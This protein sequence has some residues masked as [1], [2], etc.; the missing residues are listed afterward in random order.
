MPHIPSFRFDMLL[1]VRLQNLGINIAFGVAFI[2]ALLIFTEYSTTAS[3]DTP[4]TLF[5]RG[6]KSKP[7]KTAAAPD[8]EGGASD[9]KFAEEKVSAPKSAS[10]K[11]TVPRMTD[12]FSWRN[13]NYVVPIPGKEDRKLLDDVSGYV[14]PGKLT[15]LMGESGAGKTTLLNVLAARTDVGVVTGDRLVNGQPLPAD[16]QSQSYVSDGFV[17]GWCT[18]VM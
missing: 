11:A 1:N 12:I 14:A 13:I 9:E 8:E 16:F 15:A 3:V 6:A 7:A 17:W 2:L 18:D 4:I 10:G 5:R